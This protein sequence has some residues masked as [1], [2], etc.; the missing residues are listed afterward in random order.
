[1]IK[2][3]FSL[4]SLFALFFIL[5]A[6]TPAYKID[7]KASA[8]IVAAKPILKSSDKLVIIT[9]KD[10]GHKKE[11]TPNT[12]P[13]VAMHLAAAFRQYAP[14]TYICEDPL[15]VEQAKAY[16]VKNK[17]TRMI[18]P[19]ILNWEDR[20]PLIS[21]LR[22]RVSVRV[23][24]I[25]VQN[26]KVLNDSTLYGNGSNKAW[27]TGKT[28]EILLDKPFQAYAASLFSNDK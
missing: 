13:I 24:V 6:C 18:Y 23:T 3:V 4:C 12:G 17:Y 27:A 16:S 25:D 7:S 5:Q 15:T 8:G 21:G 28:P 20:Q 22:D 26:D 11:I 19:V 14:D 1:M 10:G 9:P 2:K